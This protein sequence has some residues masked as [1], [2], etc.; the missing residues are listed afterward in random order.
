MICFR[1]G[2]LEVQLHWSFLLL[3]GLAAALPNAPLVL[4]GLGAA[5]CHELG[6]LGAMMLAG[7]PP[8]RLRLSLLGGRLQSCAFACRRAELLCLGAG[9]GVNLLLAA[10]FAAAGSYE[11]R[12]FSAMNL[13]LGG[14]NLLPVQGLDG[15]RMLGLL[16][17]RRLGQKRGWVVLAVVSLAA[18]AGVGGWCFELA[19]AHPELPLLRL[20]VLVPAA[21][22]F[23][24]LKD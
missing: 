17:P 24:W 2:R 11:L 5:A 7:L 21:A 13:V 9:P 22:F 19:R 18:L 6:H 8:A 20:V 3:V 14:F 12:L 15:G 23:R 4:L 16:L 1:L 10:A